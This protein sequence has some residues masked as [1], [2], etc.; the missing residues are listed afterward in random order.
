MILNTLKTAAYFW[1]TFIKCIMGRIILKT[2][3]TFEMTSGY[4]RQSEGI[5]T[6]VLK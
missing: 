1:I 2:G 5:K 3:K 6:I 4:L